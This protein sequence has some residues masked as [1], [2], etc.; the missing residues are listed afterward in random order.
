MLFFL[1]L[2]Q[3]YRGVSAPTRKAVGEVSKDA[4]E[5]YLK[6]ETTAVPK[7]MQIQE[8]DS[9]KVKEKKQKALKALKKKRRCVLFCPLCVLPHL[10]PGAV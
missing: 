7:W 1:L 9:E 10:D 6:G 5:R 8:G 2:L 3:N 4:Y